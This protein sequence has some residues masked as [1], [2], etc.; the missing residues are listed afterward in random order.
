MTTKNSIKRREYIRGH[1][2]LRQLGNG[3]WLAVSCHGGTL[4]DGVRWKSEEKYS[5]ESR[6]DVVRAARCRWGHFNF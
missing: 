4:P 1:Y 2:S 3:V 5:G 6:D